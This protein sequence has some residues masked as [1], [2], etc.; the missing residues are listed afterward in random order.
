MLIQVQYF[1]KLIDES[2]VNRLNASNAI[3]IQEHV[4]PLN[5]S[6]LKLTKKILIL[7]K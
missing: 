2:G 3:A 4:K 6:G 1:N 5:G 7:L